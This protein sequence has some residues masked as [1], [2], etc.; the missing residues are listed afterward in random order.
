MNKS[1]ISSLLFL[2]CLTIGAQTTVYVSPAG[3]DTWNGSS[4]RPFKTLE[5]AISQAAAGTDTLFIEVKP[6]EY[7]LK[8]T[9][10]LTN[11]LPC[12]IVIRGNA[13]QMPRFIAGVKVSNWESYKDGIYRAYVPEVK[14]YGFSFEQFYVNGQR[15]VW[16]RTPNTDWS[17]I[18]RHRESTILRKS[19]NHPDY[20]VQRLWLDSVD[21]AY[22]KNIPAEDLQDMRFRFYHKWDITQKIA[23]R[24]SPDS[25][26]IYIDGQGM[27]PWNPIC[28]GSRYLMYG[29]KAALDVPGEW[30]LDKKE[31]FVYYM[32][33]PNENMQEVECIAPTLEKWITVN[34]SLEQPV[35]DL[36]IENIS[37]AY[38]SYYMPEGGNE[39]EQAAASTQAAMEFNYAQ[40]IVLKNC[41]L[42]HTGA[43]GIWFKSA[44]FDNQI[45]HCYLNDLGAGGIKLGEPV[46]RNDSRLISKRNHVDNCIITNTGHVLPCGV[47]VAIFH[48]A[49][50]TVTHNDI[51]NLMYSGV[52]VGWAWDYNFSKKSPFRSPAV[53]NHIM[54]NHIHHV[55]WGELSDMG[56][57]YTLGES[58]GTKVNNNVIHD[59]LSYD[60]GGWGL[61]TDE[62]S[63]DV[64]MCNN[65]VYRCK[66]GGF[67]QH[68]GKE[69]KIENNILAF[70][71]Y[72]QVQFTR[73]EQHVSFSFRH[74]IIL[75]DKGKTF[76]GNGW[77]KGN[78][79]MD[80]NLLWHIDGQPE[81]GKMTFEE[82]KKVRG[83]RHSVI[84][85]PL[86]EDAGN[87]NYHFRSLKAA[88]KIGFKVFD[89]SLVGVY[90]SD[91]WKKKA[92]MSPEL[93]EKFKAAAKVRLAK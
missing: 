84:M 29:F 32:P 34:G 86:F 59:I 10:Q 39:P 54:Y 16:A 12:P 40:N 47:G 76:Y 6:G 41:E 50:N 93:I 37:F 90:G 8:K 64:E 52:S 38:T 77:D 63:T 24:V 91:S 49:D 19:G 9:L 33:R 57:V 74:N 78:L 25:G 43:Y 22:L 30:Y 48:S 18:Q 5:K 11:A 60:Y 1:F 79:D 15:A 62:G 55:G 66:S 2:G 70:G 46:F 83:G 68:Y 69:N 65:L 89:T 42:Q 26:S 3:N 72:Y 67:H 56:A 23:S 87:D 73:P 44:C 75:Q 7:H 88:K 20:A 14:L 71:H 13:D 4:D 58:Y 45:N 36:R 31:G 35:K 81:F 85:D 80:Y 28:K 17:F 53:N 92:E 51:F 82:W 21:V 61:Y 27:K